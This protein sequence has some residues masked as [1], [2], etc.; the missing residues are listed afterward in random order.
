MAEKNENKIAV[1]IRLTN[2]KN[3]H[4][5]GSPGDSFQLNDVGEPAFRKNNISAA[6]PPVV[7][8]DADSGYEVGSDWFDITAGDAFVCLDATV[9]AAVWKQTT[10]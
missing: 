1:L 3:L 8:D 4:L 5:V 6:V 10:P 7:T 2:G 9:G